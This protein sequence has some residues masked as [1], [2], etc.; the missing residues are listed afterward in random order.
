[1]HAGRIIQIAFES[2][3]E[4]FSNRK[5]LIPYMLEGEARAYNQEML[6]RTQVRSQALFY[7]FEESRTVWRYYEWVNGRS[8]EF[9]REQLVSLLEQIV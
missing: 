6:E 9:G 2:T 3:P 8:G 5:F 7:C 1:M 4:K